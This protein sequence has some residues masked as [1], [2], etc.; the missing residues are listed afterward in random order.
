MGLARY[1][2]KN[3]W[4]ELANFDL[5]KES[6]L[7]LLYSGQNE[8]NVFAAKDGRSSGRDFDSSLVPRDHLDSRLLA[9]KRN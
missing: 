2:A 3:N 1:L 7:D 4:L 6:E 8:R 9:G 5:Q